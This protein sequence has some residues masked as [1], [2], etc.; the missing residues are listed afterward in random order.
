M[1]FEV[2][3]PAR[4][5]QYAEK[6]VNYRR[7]TSQHVDKLAQMMRRGEWDED[8]AVEP[9]AFNQQGELIEGKHRMLAVVKAGVPIGFW[10]VRGVPKK[11]ENIIDTGKMRRA[12]DVFRRLYGMPDPK[13]SVGASNLLWHFEHGTLRTANGTR[14]DVLNLQRVYE[15]N[16]EIED[17]IRYGRKLYGVYRGSAAAYVFL[18]YVLSRIDKQA[19]DEFISQLA[20]ATEI[21]LGDSNAILALRRSMLGGD[22]K[23][24]S[25]SVKVGLWKAFHAWN[26]WRDGLPLRA[27]R[28]DHSV[29][30]K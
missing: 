18:H 20:L 2:I 13:V 7:Q 6:A 30:P 5:A 25:A 24:V 29:Y 26:R 11:V 19:A 3:S 1:D 14:T 12:E 28:A 23:D 27:A 16:P 8:N 17:S 4:A 10:V 15:S 21:E 9:I 22:F